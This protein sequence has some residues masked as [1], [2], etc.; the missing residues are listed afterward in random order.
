LFLSVED[1][2]PLTIGAVNLPALII[3]ISMT[4]VTTPWGAKMAHALPAKT[5][6]RIFAVFIL[7]VA[8]NMLRKA[9]GA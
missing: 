8:A 2:P 9:L 5:L 4:L 3:A 7:I 1:A 6:R